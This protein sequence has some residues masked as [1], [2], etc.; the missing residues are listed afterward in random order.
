M[1]RE[2]L[3]DE[4]RNLRVGKCT[5]E[6]FQ[7]ERIVVFYNVSWIGQERRSFQVKIEEAQPQP[8]NQPMKPP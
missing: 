6:T 7:G 1:W 4:V 8:P 2:V 5:A 3:Y